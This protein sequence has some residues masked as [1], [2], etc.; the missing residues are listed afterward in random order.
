MGA[1]EGVEAGKQ[2]EWK[3]TKK[4][5]KKERTRRKTEEKKH[6]KRRPPPQRRVPAL[7]GTVREG[8]D[9]KAQNVTGEGDQG[10]SWQRGLAYPKPDPF[11][12][13]KRAPG[14]LERGHGDFCICPTYG[15]DSEPDETQTQLAYPHLIKLN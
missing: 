9:A 4:Q 2:G 6:K 14:A 5:R 3:K 12:W 10:D 1:G 11:S 8:R 13:A 7:L 15:W